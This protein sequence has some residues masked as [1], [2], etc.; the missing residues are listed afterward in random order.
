MVYHS[1]CSISQ[2]FTLGDKFDTSKVEDMVQMFE[3]CSLP[4]GFILGDKFDTSNVKDMC[5]MFADCT[6]PKGFTLG[7]RF[8]TSKVENMRG[9]FADCTLNDLSKMVYHSTYIEVNLFLKK[10]WNYI[11]NMY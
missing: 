11:E 3:S 9:M 8:A 6:L 1:T 10:Q 7:D 4:E 2:G 5:A